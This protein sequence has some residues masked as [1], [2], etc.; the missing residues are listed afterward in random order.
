MSDRREGPT[1]EFLDVLFR[2]ASIVADAVKKYLIRK[3]LDDE[4][5]KATSICPTRGSHVAA[6]ALVEA[7]MP[8]TPVKNRKKNIEGIT[9]PKSNVL[10]LQYVD[11]ACG[12]DCSILFFFYM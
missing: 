9:A 10:L 11:L 7:R 6:A 5:V 4:A 3:M 8:L 12:M 2:K 1:S